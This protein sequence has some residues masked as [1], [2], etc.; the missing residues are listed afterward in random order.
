MN[1]VFI[2]LSCGCNEAIG[3]LGREPPEVIMGMI[4]EQGICATHGKQTIV[5]VGWVVKQ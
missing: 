4:G 2:R 5:E 1:E 3:L